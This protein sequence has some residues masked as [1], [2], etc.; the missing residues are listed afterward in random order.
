[1]MEAIQEGVSGIGDPAKT[2]RQINAWSGG[3]IGT[4]L[5]ACHCRRKCEVVE[6]WIS[7]LI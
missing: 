4:V 5:Q 1:M 6:N 3:I 2:L 7:C